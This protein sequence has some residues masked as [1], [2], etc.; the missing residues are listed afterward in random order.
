MERVYADVPINS[1]FGPAKSFS[2]FG[3]VVTVIVKNAFVIAGVIAFLLLVFGAFTII[4][5]A[6]AGDTKQ[7]EKGRQAIVG[8]VT[9]LI[10]VVGSF[11]I[12]QIVEKLTGVPLLK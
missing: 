12:V 10:I 1:I 6:G 2:T 9:G 8:A 4:M 11:W 3:D 5:G 7:L